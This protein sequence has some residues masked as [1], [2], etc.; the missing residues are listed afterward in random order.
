[1]ID[2]DAM[3]AL[4]RLGTEPLPWWSYA[5]AAGAIMGALYVLWRGRR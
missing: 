5:G 2:V 3:A 1:M 4:S